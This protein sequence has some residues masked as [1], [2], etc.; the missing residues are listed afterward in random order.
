MTTIF[1]ARYGSRCLA[2]EGWI[3]EGDAAT[4]DEGSVVHASCPIPADLRPARSVC[5][6]CFMEPSVTGE[7]GC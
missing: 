1:A 4:W 7:C 6:S 3:S 2:C 5:G